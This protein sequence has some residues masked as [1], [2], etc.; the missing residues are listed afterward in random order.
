VLENIVLPNDGSA[1]L[2]GTQDLLE[3]EGRLASAF[4]AEKTRGIERYFDIV[5]V[6]AGSQSE[7]IVSRND[8]VHVLGAERA[9]AVYDAL[10]SYIG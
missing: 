4:P 2:C 5:R 6:H 8:I 3:C 9:D 1:L 7:D 10:K